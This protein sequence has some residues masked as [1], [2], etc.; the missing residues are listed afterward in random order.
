L[1]KDPEDADGAE[2]KGADVAKGKGADGVAG[3]EGAAG[4]KVQEVADGKGGDGFKGGR[5]NRGIGVCA[6]LTDVEGNLDFF[7]KYVRISKVIEWV[8]S[9]KNRLRFKQ[10]DSMF[11]FGGDCQDRGIG[12]IRFVNL[13]LKFKSEYPNRVEFI[14]GNRDANKIRI[15][16][17]LSEKIYATGVADRKAESKYLAKYDNFPYWVNKSER[18]TLRTYLNDNNF[19]IDAVSRLKYILDY[20]MGSND[21]FDK[22]RKE[23][24]IILNK[25]PDLI[26]DNDI[27]ASF[28]NS[29]SPNPKNIKNTND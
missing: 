13:L 2:G 7:E 18:I 5:A 29:V 19:K 15:S 24:S 14:I 6:Y 28:L 20:T 26:S 23:L 4:A 3:A 17:E 12:D 1:Y 27:V 8:D 25:S 10:K 11:V 16:S 9:K 22:R 21:S